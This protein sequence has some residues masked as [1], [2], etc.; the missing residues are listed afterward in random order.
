MKN[1]F[2]ISIVKLYV[3]D[4]SGG[5]KML[6][7]YPLLSLL[8]DCLGFMSINFVKCFFIFVVDIM[9]SLRIIV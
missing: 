4:I 5:K 9:K 7:R 2:R 8:W 1:I 6:N 3:A